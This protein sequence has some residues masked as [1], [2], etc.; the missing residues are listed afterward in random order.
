MPLV[1]TRELVERAAAGRRAVA[2]FNVIN[3]EYAEAVTAGEIG[4]A[5]V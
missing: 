4:R 5:H 3:L 2:A 1:S